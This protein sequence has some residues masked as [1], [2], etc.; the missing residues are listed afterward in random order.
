[1]AEVHNRFEEEYVFLG[2]PS[3]FPIYIY[4]YI[5]ADL[6]AG[7]IAVHAGTTVGFYPSQSYD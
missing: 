1:M 3:S 5:D 6:L 4:I 2:V 7:V